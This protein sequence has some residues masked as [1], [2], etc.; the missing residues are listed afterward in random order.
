MLKYKDIKPFFEDLSIMF[1]CLFTVLGTF[2]WLNY[3]GLVFHLNF[4]F[5]AFICCL[6]IVALF[7]LLYLTFPFIMQVGLNC[8]F[9]FL[10][11]RVTEKEYIFLNEFPCDGSS[12][13]EK[14]DVNHNF[15]SQKYFLIH[16]KSQDEVIVLVSTQSL[17]ISKGEKYWITTAARS[18][19][20]IACE[21]K[22]DFISID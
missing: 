9:D 5:S 7:L 11:Q 3:M 10:F 8:M 15:V 14:F 17:N 12:F 6:W 13:S 16:V 21:E 1:F 20:V 22:N 19:V 2:L 4:V 18:H